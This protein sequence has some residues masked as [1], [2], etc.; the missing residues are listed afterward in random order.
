MLIF[1]RVQLVLLKC[2]LNLM[3]DMS[4]VN[5]LIKK[6]EGNMCKITIDQYSCGKVKL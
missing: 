4:L 1:L 3:V 6:V 5:G 2:K